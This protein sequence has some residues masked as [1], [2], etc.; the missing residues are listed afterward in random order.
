MKKLTPI[1]LLLITL[2]LMTISCK[3]E[4]I[5]EPEVPEITRRV[6][7]F[8]KGIMTDIYYWADNVPDIDVR[9]EADPEEYFDKLLHAEDK[10][11][12]IT[13]DVQQ[14]EDSFQGVETT[15]GY[16][17]AFGRFS[18]TGNIFALVEF[19]YPNT[20]AAEAGIK[21]G[22]ILI[23]NDG[24]DLT[25]QNYTDLLYAPQ[26]ELTL[27]V[28]KEDGIH[29]VP[30]TVSLVAKK[31]NLDPVMITSV[32]EH[33]GKKIGYLFYAQF[34]HNYNSRLNEAFSYFLEQGITDLVVDLR[35]NPGGTTL[36]ARH[37]CSSIAPLDV[38]NNNSVLVTYQWNHSYQTMF[39]SEKVE[40]QLRERFISDVPN[41]LGLN[42]VYILTGPGTASASE[43]TIT[44]LRPYM[45]VTTIGGTTYGKYTASLTFTP[46]DYYRD[47]NRYKDIDNWGLQ[48]IVLRYAN[49]EGVTDFKD[50]FTPDIAVS[51]DLLSGIP[52]GDKEEPL[53]KA[54]I[55]DITGTQ[56]I[57]QKKAQIT[58]T[59]FELFD[60]GFSKFD[61]NKRE[62][63]INDFDPER[64]RK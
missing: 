28:S 33:E 18:N 8:I 9:Y 47:E 15:F 64:L 61:D 39:E 37:L 24:N 16:S 29:T 41:K 55:E 42:N 63:L 12:Y 43:L 3:E 26:V 1:W 58:T 51:D 35:Y 22:D 44:G 48:P 5:P 56:V 38:V 53:L 23:Q 57:A 40:S 36:A 21:R 54:A 2:S 59:G 14:L 49:S 10:W 34:I 45:D 13:D 4:P 11:S 27:G 62:L 31:L 25:D 30:G 17:L 60:R 6:N 32:V 7:S 50:G 46:D 52:L 20:P 19:V